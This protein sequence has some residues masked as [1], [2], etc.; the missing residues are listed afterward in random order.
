MN[1]GQDAIRAIVRVVL[2]IRRVCMVAS[3]GPSCY[4]RFRS[5]GARSPWLRDLSAVWAMATLHS[6]ARVFVHAT[7]YRLRSHTCTAAATN[8]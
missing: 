7:C 8:S 3:R 4:V 5:T 1:S 6:V 2:F